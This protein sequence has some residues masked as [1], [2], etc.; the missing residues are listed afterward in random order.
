MRPISILSQS[1]RHTFDLIENIADALES[2]A[3]PRMPIN[4]EVL[5]NS[6]TTQIMYQLGWHKNSC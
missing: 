1:S 5:M 6:W 3:V 4:I 2:L